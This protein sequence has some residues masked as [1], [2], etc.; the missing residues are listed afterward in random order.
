M[1]E[2]SITQ[3]RN[4]YARSL[5]LLDVTAGRLDL[6][7]CALELPKVNGLAVISGRLRMGAR[8]ARPG[9][10]PRCSIPSRTPR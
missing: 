5:D 1:Q 8:P 2:I 10:R 6:V 7:V 9:P 3:Y 4:A